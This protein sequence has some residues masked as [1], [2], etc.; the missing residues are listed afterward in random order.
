[1]ADPPGTTRRCPVVTARCHKRGL[2]LPGLAR[3]LQLRVEQTPFPIR[4]LYADPHQTAPDAAG[5]PQ[6]IDPCR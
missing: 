4:S 1:M 2:C 6:G 3:T 5:A